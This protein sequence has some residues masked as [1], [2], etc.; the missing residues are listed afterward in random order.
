MGADP[1][2]VG[3]ASESTSSIA[4]TGGLVAKGEGIGTPNPDRLNPPRLDK[5]GV[6]GGGLVADAGAAGTG[7]VP[8]L[9]SA[10]LGHLRLV[11]V[12]NNVSH[13]TCKGEK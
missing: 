10:H 8:L 5:L 4:D 1:E 3:G 6:M 9:N 12:P 11:S 13:Y 2:G 7:P